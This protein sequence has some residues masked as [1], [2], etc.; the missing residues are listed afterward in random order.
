[1]CVRFFLVCVHGACICGA[2]AGKKRYL[3]SIF[4]G[5][6]GSMASVHRGSVIGAS[7]TQSRAT[8]HSPSPS[9]P[10]PMPAHYYGFHTKFSQQS[11]VHSGCH[12][13]VHRTLWISLKFQYSKMCTAYSNGVLLNNGE[14]VLSDFSWG[15][16]KWLFDVAPQTRAKYHVRGSMGGDDYTIITPPPHASRQFSSPIFWPWTCT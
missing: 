5:N 2:K 3:K 1:M 12:C 11:R 14:P 9:L 16:R 15:R 4:T 13:K 7:I 6:S 10:P 8:L